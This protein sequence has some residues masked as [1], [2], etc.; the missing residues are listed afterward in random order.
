MG[1]VLHTLQALFQR[2]ASKSHH[3]VTHAQLSKCTD[4]ACDLLRSSREGETLSVR[5]PLS[6]PLIVKACAIGEPHLR[7][8]SAVR[9]GVPAEAAHRL[10]ELL[11]RVQGVVIVPVIGRLV[12]FILIEQLSQSWQQVTIVTPSIGM[13][14][15]DNLAISIAMVVIRKPFIGYA[16]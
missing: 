1:E 14:A 6:A 15:R 7:W 4:V 8:V 3:K 2:V 5:K 13:V 16:A 12:A 11:W 10:C 9:F